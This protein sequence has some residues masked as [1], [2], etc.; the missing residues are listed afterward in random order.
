MMTNRRC[1]IDLEDEKYFDSLSYPAL[2][3]GCDK[4]SPCHVFHLC[5]INYSGMQ[6]LGLV[7]GVLAVMAG[8][9][10]ILHQCLNDMGCMDFCAHCSICLNQCHGQDSD[11][12]K[13]HNHDRKRKEKY[14]QNCVR[15]RNIV[16]N[17]AANT[18]NDRVQERRGNASRPVRCYEYPAGPSHMNP[19]LHLWV[20][21]NM[22]HLRPVAAAAPEDRRQ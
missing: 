2:F 6:N 5:K 22:V 12:C 11:K 19:P 4:T 10:W 16:S 9:F 8:I 1:T 14:C 3:L 7:I 20:H 18:S 17:E 13:G 15:R 21:A